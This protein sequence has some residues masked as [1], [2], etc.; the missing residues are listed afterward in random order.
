MDKTTAPESVQTELMESTETVVEWADVKWKVP[1]SPDEW[2][3]QALQA[4]EQGKPMT[5]LEH[6]LGPKQWGRFL[7]GD[8]STAGDAA[9]LTN[10]IY[11]AYGEADEG[12]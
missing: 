4:L 3:A 6:V 2:P 12:E 7:R 11:G 10:L 9:E 5:F 8:R 1:A